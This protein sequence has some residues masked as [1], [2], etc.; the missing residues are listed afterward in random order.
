MTSCVAVPKSQKSNINQFIDGRLRESASAMLRCRP[1]KPDPDDGHVAEDV[2]VREKF[3]IPG[4][5]V[6]PDFADLKWTTT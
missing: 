1:A 3:R 5:I 4:K 2:A 6:S